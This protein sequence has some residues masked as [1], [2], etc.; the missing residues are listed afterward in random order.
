MGVQP[1]PARQPIPIMTPSRSLLAVLLLALVS[2]SLATKDDS[3]LL[4]RG[5]PQ[6]SLSNI[7]DTQ[8]V[9]LLTHVTGLAPA[10]V[11]TDRSQFPQVDLFSS[12]AVNFLVALE[13]VTPEMLKE[14]RT[15]FLGGDD[16]QH[17]TIIKDAYP[18]DSLT[19]LT[20]ILTGEEPSTHGIMGHSWK[21]G[22]AVSILAYS[23]NGNCL[24]PKILDRVAV[25]SEGDARIVSVS[26]SKQMAA[27]L[28]IHTELKGDHPQWNAE[29][30]YFSKER[31][32]VDLYTDRVVA[33]LALIRTHAKDLSMKLTTTAGYALAAELK[34]IALLPSRVAAMTSA[35]SDIPDFVSVGVSSI[36]ELVKTFGANSPQVIDGLRMLDLAL[37]RAQKDIAQMYDGAL[38]SEVVGLSSTTDEHTFYTQEKQAKSLLRVEAG[39]TPP[40]SKGFSADQVSAFQTKFWVAIVLAIAFIAGTITIVKMDMLET[41]LIY[42]TTDGPRPIPNVQ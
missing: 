42:R 40:S 4:L 20:N 2:F 18:N 35:G 28:G 11:G 13:A 8:V 37:M 31:G 30:L 36:K 1:K 26:S 17:T 7:R 19:T 16:A 34:A 22:R 3:F 29:S 14:A 23:E 38:L 6:H 15:V 24:Y 12:P 32:L 9:D 41:S 5:A 10:H 25:V 21:V 33:D 39:P 27:A